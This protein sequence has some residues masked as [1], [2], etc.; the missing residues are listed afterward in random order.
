[1]MSLRQHYLH[2]SGLASYARHSD[3]QVSYVLWIETRPSQAVG[4][5]LEFL[6]H[7]IG[8]AH[9]AACFRPI[10][11]ESGMEKMSKMMLIRC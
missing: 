2:S 11:W 4:A 9:V 7:A 6:Y 3:L 1:M 5:V 8:I 10:S